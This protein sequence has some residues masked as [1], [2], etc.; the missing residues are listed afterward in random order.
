M[1]RFNKESAIGMDY[2]PRGIRHCLIPDSDC[3][4]VRFPAVKNQAKVD[5]LIYVCLMPLSSASS[6]AKVE[7]FNEISKLCIRPDSYYTNVSEK[8]A[9]K[10]NQPAVW[11]VVLR[12]YSNL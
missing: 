5:A 2:T 7:I 8:V 11:R 9:L 10:M 6:T 1:A 3:E 12:T 4:T